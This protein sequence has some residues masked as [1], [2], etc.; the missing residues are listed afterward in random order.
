MGPKDTGKRADK[1]GKGNPAKY[2]DKPCMFVLVTASVL[3]LD[4][5]T[6]YL[7]GHFIG[8]PDRSVDIID[9][10]LSLSYTTNTGAAFSMLQ[11]RNIFLTMAAAIVIAAIIYLYCCRKIPGKAALFAAMIVGGAMG[12]LADRLIQGHVIDF[13]DFSFWPA[14]NAADMGITLGVIGV[15]Y[16]I[17]GE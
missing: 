3:M 10:I 1:A 16:Y 12:N 8:R 4:Q 7:A 14:F 6:K 15:L 9:G 11:G 13:I 5:L 17:Y 2:S